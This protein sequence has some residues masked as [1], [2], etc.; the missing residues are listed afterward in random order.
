[1]P[2]AKMAEGVEFVEGG[3]SEK[4]DAAHLAAFRNAQ[5]DNATTNDTDSYLYGSVE[6]DVPRLVYWT[7]SA[8]ARKVILKKVV[9]SDKV[10]GSDMTFSTFDKPLGGKRFAI[11]KGYSTTA[12]TPKGA[13]NALSGKLSYNSTG[14]IWIGELPYGW[15]IIKEKDPERFFYVVVDQSGV[16]ETL[17]EDGKVKAGGYTNRSDANT[18]AK[19]KYDALQAARKP[20]N[21]N[22]NG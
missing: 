6:G 5:D 14:I 18:A 19:N 20:S 9:Q 21:S 15:Y 2:F 17:G 12:Y 10:E 8:G 7:G 4:Y 16:Y 11:Y 13:A 22:T 3:G 1:M